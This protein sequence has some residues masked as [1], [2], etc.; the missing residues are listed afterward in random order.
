MRHPGLGPQPERLMDWLQA[1]VQLLLRGLPS[2]PPDLFQAQPER[3]MV[4]PAS[5]TAGHQRFY[6]VP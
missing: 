2:T 6:S 5:Q 4:R 3:E 1:S